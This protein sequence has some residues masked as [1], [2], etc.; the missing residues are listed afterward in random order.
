MSR[1]RYMFWLGLFLQAA[2][3][4]FLLAMFTEP[5]PVGL[6]L[7]VLGAVL[8]GLSI[9]GAPRFSPAAV[10]AYALT[11]VFSL[12]LLPYPQCLGGAFML[13]GLVLLV[14]PPVRSALSSLS[15]GLLVTGVICLAEAAMLPL[16]MSV[17]A[18]VHELPGLAGLFS[19]LMT[20]FGHESARHATSFFVQGNAQVHE[21][22]VNSEY[23]GWPVLLNAVCGLFFWQCIYGTA[24]KLK[25]LLVFAAAALVYALVRYFLLS[26]LYLDLPLFALFWDPWVLCISFLPL[27]VFLASAQPILSVSLARRGV[28]EHPTSKLIHPAGPPLQ[29]LGKLVLMGGLAA[30]AI[31]LAAV[32]GW[33]DPGLKKPGRIIIDET[34]S[35]WELMDR[36]YDTEWYGEESGYNYYCLA[37]FLGWHYRVKLNTAAITAALLG[38]CDILVIKTPTS[39]FTPEE[40]EA[41][42]AFVRRGGGLFL[43]GDHTNVFGTSTYLNVIARRFGLHYNL[44]ATYDLRTGGLSLYR[45]PALL[46]HPI[47]QRLP[48]FLFGTSCT[49]DVPAG[50]QIPIGGYALRVAGHD[51]SSGAFFSTST[52]GPHIGF[53]V[54]PQLAAVKFH[55]GRVAAFTD[56]TVFSNFWMFVPGKPELMLGCT[57]WL[58]RSNRYVMLPRVLLLLGVLIGACCLVRLN[59]HGPDRLPLGLAAVTLGCLAGSQ[60]IAALNRTAYPEPKPH[61]AFTTICFDQQYSRFELPSEKLFLQSNLDFHTFYTWVQRV[62]YVPRVASRLADAVAESRGLVLLNPAGPIAKSELQRLKRYVEGGGVL[63]VLDAAVQKNSIANTVLAEFGLTIGGEVYAGQSISN[64]AGQIVAI[65]QTVRFI[66]GGEPI[67]FSTNHEAVLSVKQQG[68]GTVIAGTDS[69]MFCM[70]SLGSVNTVPSPMQRRLYDVLFELFRRIE[71]TGSSIAGSGPL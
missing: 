36:K 13:A 59:Q 68:R 25:D 47:V 64:R 32:W 6:A 43:I 21:F 9:P 20:A 48:P 17:G 53:G 19:W 71:I 66:S 23:F 30:A 62:G 29:G 44:D 57:E 5:K 70:R 27:F 63:F 34:H 58:N 45:R 24:H 54:F 14:L 7:L 60:V 10:A 40:I 4:Q 8:M 52:D 51:Y 31:C 55:R 56:S 65:N 67:L 12:A 1:T 38:D 15:F 26:E 50:G 41:I 37:K 18:R 22:T 46:P 39:A 69:E 33:E 61:T 28:H 16:F 11:A 42:E 49:L 2:G 35:K 3:W